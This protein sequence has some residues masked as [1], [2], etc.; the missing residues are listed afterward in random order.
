[1]AQINPVIVGYNR[2]KFARQSQGNTPLIGDYYLPFTDLT[3]SKLTELELKN[4]TVPYTVAPKSQWTTQP[5]NDQPWYS[6][7]LET[8]GNSTTVNNLLVKSVGE[9]ISVYRQFTNI[10]YGT[11]QLGVEYVPIY[12]YTTDKPRNNIQFNPYGIYSLACLD[13][14]TEDTI[15]TYNYY[16]L[17]DKNLD[18]PGLD[19]VSNENKHG[20]IPDY[21][22]I[23]I[24]ND[25]KDEKYWE[26]KLL[27]VSVDDNKLI[28]TG[29][30]YTK[31]V[32]NTFKYLRGFLA[33]QTFAPEPIPVNF[34]TYIINHSI[35]ESY[36][37]QITKKARLTM[38]KT[39]PSQYQ[40][41]IKT[42]KDF[43]LTKSVDRFVAGLSG[44]RSDNDQPLYGSYTI[45]WT[46]KEFD[47]YSGTTETVNNI[48][49]PTLYD[50][51]DK[52]VFDFNDFT[53]NYYYRSDTGQTYIPKSGYSEI[54][55]LVRKY[56]TY[57]KY[58]HIETIES[59]IKAPIY[60][61]YYHLLTGYKPL[62]TRD[63]A[64]SLTFT[65]PITAKVKIGFYQ[66]DVSESIVNYTCIDTIDIDNKSAT[67]LNTINWVSLELNLSK[68]KPTTINFNG[69]VLGTIYCSNSQVNNAIIGGSIPSGNYY[70]VS[71]MVYDTSAIDSLFSSWAGLWFTAASNLVDPDLPNDW[72][73]LTTLSITKRTGKL[74]YARILAAFNNPWNNANIP[75]D[76][77]PPENGEYHPMF[78]DN[79]LG[80][81]N[82]NSPQL[83]DLY[84][85][86]EAAKYSRNSV[87]SSKPR[88]NNLGHYLEKIAQLLGYW[89][90]ENGKPLE[91]LPEEETR[92][93]GKVKIKP[94]EYGVNKFAQKGMV[95][96]WLP[97]DIDNKGNLIDGEYQKIHDIPQLLFSVLDQLNHSFGIQEASNITIESNGNKYRYPNQISLLA[98]IG[99][100]IK[101]NSKYIES[102][103]YSS[104]V[105]QEQTKEI[106]G[107]LGLPTIFK[108]IRLSTDK[109]GKYVN[110]PYVGI[111]PDNSLQKEIAT[112][113]YNI[114]IISGQ[115][116]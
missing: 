97:N 18:R 66:V 52:T 109:R 27:D 94:E 4:I 116:M 113:T 90:D 12:K 22:Q 11:Y 69:L 23:D 59:K 96:R 81:F 1:M 20:Y 88:I 98:D 95:I 41:K 2:I 79:E 54:Y 55:S 43:W 77:N 28:K 46:Y 84:T 89:V 67:R 111:H 115:L 51:V 7:E 105:T 102:T 101:A 32:K 87:D 82:L 10:Y 112:V 49:T 15:E 62:D 3:S 93:D 34:R 19:P 53:S 78:S 40:D 30:P 38:F 68:D 50:G 75:S 5:S 108:T 31:E 13:I 21:L 71:V 92:V 24:E 60:P 70:P 61:N 99:R 73:Q 37:E 91:K 48:Y 35:A 25:S 65:S 17:I 85:A 6:S 63:I 8:I 44:V 76:N 72:N 107:G 47:N 64:P 104:L 100:D 58:F 39:K 103:H 80:V 114:G 110:I 36:L 56:K 16:Y 86:L 14:K 9:M 42:S 57:T 26:V 83:I 33:F 45:N 29:N 106:I 74:V